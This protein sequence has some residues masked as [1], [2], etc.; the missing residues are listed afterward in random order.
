MRTHHSRLP[1]LLCLGFT[2]ALSGCQTPI[3]VANGNQA[4]ERPPAASTTGGFDWSYD[5]SGDQPVRPVQVF[6][7]GIK[8]WLQMAPQQVLPA[9]FVA[10]EPVPFDVQPPYL[11]VLGSPKRIDLIATSYRAVVVR[12]E[13]A[14][15]TAPMRSEAAKA[16]AQ[17]IQQ[18]PSS[19]IPKE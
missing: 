16:A 12:R 9:I 13:G 5:I 19:Q 2:L 14:S 11:V 6:G 3:L 4:A 7:N 15:G 10:G 8:T 1:A 17:R 18:V